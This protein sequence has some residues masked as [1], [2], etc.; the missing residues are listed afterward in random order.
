M[1]D[2]LKVKVTPLSAIGNDLDG[3]NRMK[4][5]VFDS[6]KLSIRSHKY[7]SHDVYPLMYKF[8]FSLTPERDHKMAH[9]HDL[10]KS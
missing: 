8:C 2:Q 6:S 7:F 1:N 10:L 4:E 9:F 5:L 3:S